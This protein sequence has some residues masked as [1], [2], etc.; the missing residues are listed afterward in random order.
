MAEFYDT[1]ALE[2]GSAGDFGGISAEGSLV[3]YRPPPPPPLSIPVTYTLEQ[4]YEE[5][6][7]P[8]PSGYPIQED[9]PARVQATGGCR[10]CGVPTQVSTGGQSGS[11]GSTP[12]SEQALGNIGPIPIPQGSKPIQVCWPCLVFWLMVTYVAVSK[13]G[14][15]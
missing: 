8:P 6:P 11:G 1:A 14:R 10:T 2:G 15:S 13:R 5:A 7:A 12:P 3:E 4:F 9:I